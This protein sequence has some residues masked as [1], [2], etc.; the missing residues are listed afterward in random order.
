MLS[1]LSFFSNKKRKEISESLSKYKVNA[2]KEFLS[3][4]NGN[5]LSSTIKDKKSPSSSS[6]GDKRLNDDQ[7]K[8]NC[9][10]I[11]QEIVDTLKQTTIKEVIPNNIANTCTNQPDPIKLTNPMT[12][13]SFPCQLAQGSATKTIKAFSNV[14]QLYENISTAFNIPINNVSINSFDL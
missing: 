13:L 4:N 1:Q 9:K 12:K 3:S 11:D 6:N 5:N 2:I 7:V 8:N 10:T 14:K